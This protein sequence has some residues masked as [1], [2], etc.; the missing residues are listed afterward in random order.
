MKKLTTEQVQSVTPIDM[1][2]ARLLPLTLL[3]LAASANTASA[4]GGNECSSRTVIAGSGLYYFN[5]QGMSLGNPSIPTS[6]EVSPAGTIQKD[7]WYEWIVPADGNYEIT[8]NQ[9]TTANTLLVVY[10]AGLVG[11]N[12]W[13]DGPQTP[14]ACNFTDEN[15]PAYNNG[16]CYHTSHVSLSCLEEG[17]VYIIRLGT[18]DYNGYGSSGH[19]KIKPG[20]TC[21]DDEP[22]GFS[23]YC[24][25]L[26]NSEGYRPVIHGTGSGSIS[27][28]DFGIW[29][30]QL[31]ASQFCL[32]YFG[33]SQ[34]QV[35]FGDGF[36]CVAPGPQGILVRFP[37]QQADSCGG[38]G[39][40]I[41]IDNMPGGT[42]ISPGM[43]LNFQGWYRDPLG[44]G[45]S[46][47][48]LTNGLSVA[49]TP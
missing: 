24:D 18:P 49:F 42:Q 3:A 40:T 46:G 4:N 6:C 44:P 28:N 38:V 16:W 32:F 19:F 12:G 34:T 21:G 8:T 15:R 9:L 30:A 36:R 27:N 31:P 20:A 43:N 45:G 26:L 2:I 14:V 25:A 1:R 10:D 47:F 23:G 37:V 41:P 11:L 7:V 33:D 5:T 13:C 29:A 17:D 35:P 48:N 22:D 39:L